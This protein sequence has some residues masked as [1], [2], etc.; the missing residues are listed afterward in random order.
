MILI[1]LSMAVLL[2]LPVFSLKKERQS[3]PHHG[4]T[5]SAAEDP[6]VSGKTQ[7]DNLRADLTPWKIR[8]FTHLQ[9]LVEQLLIA[10]SDC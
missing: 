8:P 5:W 3:L 9:E 2:F 6:T 1:L 10:P 7:A 4:Q